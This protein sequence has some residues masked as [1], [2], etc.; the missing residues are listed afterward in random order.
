MASTSR[1]GTRENNDLKSSVSVRWIYGEMCRINRRLYS[2][3]RGVS[4]VSDCSV[5]DSEK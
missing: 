2:G 1:G 3:V 5:S 4:C